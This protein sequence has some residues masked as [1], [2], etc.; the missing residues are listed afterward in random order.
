MILFAHAV[1]RF[2][3]VPKE[4]P[5]FDPLVNA[6][7]P[8]SSMVSSIHN[9]LA[10]EK[11]SWNEVEIFLSCFFKVPKSQFLKYS[12]KDLSMLRIKVLQFFTNKYEQFR[13]S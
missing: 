2:G 7:N 10:A 4:L 11:D 13:E 3:F 5:L 1:Q 6:K 9:Q 8:Y 12:Q